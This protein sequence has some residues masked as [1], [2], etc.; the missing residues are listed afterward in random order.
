MRKKEQIDEKSNAKEWDT[1]RK[2]ET[3]EKE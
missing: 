3:N 1:E 2:R